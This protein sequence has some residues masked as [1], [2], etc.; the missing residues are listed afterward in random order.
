MVDAGDR[1]GP[2][3]VVGKL[4]AGGM[5]EVYLAHDE[6]LDRDVAL[7]V[8]PRA[9]ARDP[10]RLA[11][12]RREALTLAAMSH[13]HI[14]V[15]HGIEEP[16]PGLVFLV[17]ER[18]EGETL[19]D[20]I[21]R[22]PLPPEEALPVAAKIAEAL[23]AAHERGVVHRDL[24]PGN[25]MLGPR[26]VVKVLDFG[27]AVSLRRQGFRRE[28]LGPRGDAA[29][30]E[31]A[32]DGAT[33]VVPSDRGG[34]PPAG[35]GGDLAPPDAATLPPGPR[36]LEATVAPDPDRS[37]GTGT[38]TEGIAGTP[39]YMSPE[40]TRGEPQD[41]RT[42]IFA[43]GA[44]L[45]EALSGTRPFPGRTLEE[46]FTAT[47]EAEPDW[48]RLPGRVPGRVRTL[49]ARCLE[50]EPDRRPGAVQPVREEIEDVL[51]IRRAA[52]VRAGEGAA[53]IP[54]NLPA[55]S[56]R[57]V[58]REA[59]LRECGELL[60]RSRLV[61]LIGVG[62]SGKTRL[63]L[64]LA[65]GRLTEY[66][67]GVWFVDLAPVVEPD[68]V[69]AVIGGPPG[70]REE[71][72]RPVLE[73]LVELLARRRT[74]L[75]LDNCEHLLEA[76]SA[77]CA[78]L[79]AACP[80]LRILATSREVLGI[81]AEAGFAVPTLGLP[82]TGVR[83]TAASLA[84]VEAVSLFVDRAGQVR[85]DFVLDDAVAPAV[86]EI[87][88]RLDGIPLA[89]ELAAAR[90][91]VLGAEQI[92]DRLDDRFRLLT[93]GS[94][95]ALPRQQTLRATLQWSFDQL[96]PQ[97]QRLFAVLAVFAG[98]WTLEAATRVW[99][100]DADEFEVLDLL[101]RLVD[102]SLVAV[103]RSGGGDPRYRYLE[104]VRQYAQE[105]L[106][107]VEDRD[108]V[109]HRFVDLFLEL[110]EAA[111]PEL[112]GPRQ[113]EWLQRLD[114]EE[115]NLVAAVTVAAAAPDL[116]V[117]ALRLAGSAARYWAARGRYALA[118]DALEAALGSG[119]R[120]DGGAERAKALV[121][122][123][124]MALYR[125]DY[126]AA[127]P[128]VEESLDIYRRLGDAKGVARALSGL[129]TVAVYRG[130]LD[131]ARSYGEEVLATYRDRGDRRGE[132]VTLHNLGFVALIGGDPATAAVRYR[133]ALSV[134]EAVGDRRHQALTGADLAVALVRTGEPEPAREALGES[135]RLVRELEA[136]REGAYALEA[137]VELALARGEFAPAA[138][139]LGAARALREESGAAL[140]GAEEQDRASMFARLE[141]SL[142]EAQ[143]AAALAEG[144]GLGFAEAVAEAQAVTEP[145]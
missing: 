79:L 142:G 91:R 70:L 12:F 100:E 61:T 34:E 53:A 136:V 52:A 16:E 25:V 58:G 140:S 80:D 93:G 59:Q 120:E 75:L 83:P 5:G 101:A 4:G 21:A 143:L 23:E 67:D 117:Q 1:L 129:A 121:R 64:E 48:D 127:G 41:V 103:D 39:G 14:A 72:G 124:G 8:L 130:D 90:I 32:A 118:Q 69:P 66:P 115:E 125:G 99:E 38:G 73:S 15:L 85:P 84:G 6:R 131:A 122:A 106:G 144:G 134:L 13:P 87:C 68:R 111:E 110:A 107:K 65:A 40:Q 60:G 78:R 82:P 26:G 116:P 113:A 108:R 135:L 9:Y 46:I 55:P 119:S 97:E 17:M 62:G 74:L 45:F 51:G 28:A 24:K 102:K 133:E 57:F 54:N 2:F 37:A 128:F 94:K 71:P 145:D 43:F 19:A 35:G 63:A 31:T 33:I 22:G 139:C 29:P 104:T 27:L 86:A 98:G 81:P 50:K 88:R 11:L 141:A 137:A 10:E 76:V 44:V 126:A 96:A 112:V 114:R 47:R 7:K 105:H 132:G 56:T 92:R 3:L 49:I 18:V 42:D 109:A 123:G 89:L 95:S 36:D 30:P 20:R 77:A 138:R